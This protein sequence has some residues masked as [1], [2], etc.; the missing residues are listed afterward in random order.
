M[1]MH[2]IFLLKNKERVNFEDK[3]IEN[4]LLSNLFDNLT[5]S[6]FE[7]EINNKNNILN[8]TTYYDNKA[9]IAKLE[10]S[11]G[12]NNIND[13]NV[14]DTVN[15]LI[16]K[17]EIRKDY[18][19][20]T[21]YDGV[22]NY[23]CN[24]SYSLMSKFERK[25]RELIYIILVKTFGL[26]WYD[27]TVSAE[28]KAEIKEVSKNKNNSVLIE[29][30]LQEMTMHD[31]EIYL[32]KPYCEVNVQKL[33]ESKEK[34]GE[35]L[36]KSKDD[37]ADLLDKCIP[38]SLWDRFF[39]T[40]I[41]NIQDELSQIR[42]YRNKL[43]HNKQFYNEDFMN[44]SKKIKSIN[45]KI[46]DAI[47]NVNKRDIDKKFILESSIAYN[48]FY[49]TKSFIENSMLN[50]PEGLFEL[51]EQSS[52]IQRS[53]ADLAFQDSM[54]IYLK[55]KETFSYIDKTYNIIGNQIKN[56]DISI[57]PSI[58]ALAEHSSMIQSLINPTLKELVETSAEVLTR[59]PMKKFIEQ[60][61]KT[62]ETLDSIS[63]KI[64]KSK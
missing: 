16:C 53:L 59:S 4:K 30:A 22:S 9:N 3:E 29:S 63:L 32:F 58:Q 19:I 8:Y 27:K 26:D 41:D 61:E 52:R 1:E 55:F 38:K 13:A 62:R 33:V 44:F 14:L 40:D 11:I 17:G 10:I 56:Y 15:R 43:S 46:L 7:K 25:L 50:I 49:Y 28:L 57:N 21:T 42:E 48:N 18:S 60:E 64:Q 6:S 24:R 51:A 20:I 5:D 37:L 34:I 54:E 31:L 39:L 36:E 47:S 2:Y 23:F 45:I 12:N 35:I